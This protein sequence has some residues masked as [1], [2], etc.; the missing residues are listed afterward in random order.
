MASSTTLA[1]VRAHW[2]AKS[3][4]WRIASL[5]SITTLMMPSVVHHRCFRF[6][7]GLFA[8]TGLA[9]SERIH[10]MVQDMI[11]AS[12]EATPGDGFA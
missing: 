8:G 12:G 9:H 7:K 4:V 6:T 5:I 2:K 10:T 3:C 1:R 11:E